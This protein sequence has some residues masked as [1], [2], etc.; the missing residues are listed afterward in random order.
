MSAFCGCPEHARGYHK[1][2]LT[3][4]LRPTVDL[5]KLLLNE[6]PFIFKVHNFPGL[7]LP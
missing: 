6:H 3:L 2:T 1:Q 7:R 5:F 4:L